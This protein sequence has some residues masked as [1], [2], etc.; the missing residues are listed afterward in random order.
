M[1]LPI[2]ISVSV[3]PVSYFFCAS[4]LLL[5]AANTTNAAEA[6]AS[7]RVV[8]GITSL[9]LF[10]N[11]TFTRIQ[12]YRGLLDRKLLSPSCSGYHFSQGASIK[13]PLRQRRRGCFFSSQLG[14]YS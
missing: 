6:M 9:P 8:T 7:L 13:S 14:V 2:L 10:E 3:A 12:V 1:M 11:S 4:A 5:E